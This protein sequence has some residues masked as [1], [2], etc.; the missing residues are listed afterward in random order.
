[1]VA[2]ALI[3]NRAQV[4]SR[5]LRMRGTNTGDLWL[6][7]KGYTNG[8]KTESAEDKVQN[9]FAELITKKQKP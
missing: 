7:E 6:M 4:V 3:I 1:M 9:Q 2:G 8:E 5:K